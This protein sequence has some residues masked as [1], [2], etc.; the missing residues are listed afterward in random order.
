MG[1]APTRWMFGDYDHRTESLNNPLA[2]VE[3][4]TSGDWYYR[5]FR[6]NQQ[7]V[8]NCHETK[9]GVEPTRE[10]AMGAAQEFLDNGHHKEPSKKSKGFSSLALYERVKKLENE[11]QETQSKLKQERELYD[12]ASRLARERYWLI[13]EAERLIRPL[14]KKRDFRLG[15]FGLLRKHHATEWVKKFDDMDNSDWDCT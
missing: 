4:L 8:R 3:R 15:F 2:E 1:Y 12:D 13:A 11:L 10:L 7:V 14:A 6:V 9:T 5:A